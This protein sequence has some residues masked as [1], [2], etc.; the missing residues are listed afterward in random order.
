[1]RTNY[2]LFKKCIEE[3]KSELKDD[4][5]TGYQTLKYK[6]VIPV[7]YSNGKLLVEIIG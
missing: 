5:K 6:K 1:M 3:I 7:C 2:P 4:K